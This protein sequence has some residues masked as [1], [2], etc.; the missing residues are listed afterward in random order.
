VLFKILYL[1]LATLVHSGIATVMLFA[2]F[3]IYSIYQLAP[4]MNGLTSL[5]DLRVAGGIMEIGG[6][7]ITFGVMTGLFFTWANRTTTPDGS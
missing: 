6:L 1:F 7:L 5:D 2:E 3:P 4:P